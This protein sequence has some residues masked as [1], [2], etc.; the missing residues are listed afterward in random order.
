MYSYGYMCV[1]L[2][3]YINIIIVIYIYINQKRS[4]QGGEG[5]DAGD[6]FVMQ[7]ISGRIISGV[8]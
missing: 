8:S 6:G 3:K 7:H 5:D 2:H 4:G 1:S